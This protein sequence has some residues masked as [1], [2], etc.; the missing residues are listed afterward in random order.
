MMNKY[1]FIRKV[2]IV[3]FLFFLFMNNVL[4]NETED[5]L[6]NLSDKIKKM[7]SEI[8][9]DNFLDDFYPIGSIYITTNSTNPSSVLGGEWEAYAQGRTLIGFGSNG[10]N[11]YNVLGAEGGNSNIKIDSV[12]ILPRH[13][14]SYTADGTITNISFKGNSVSTSTNSWSHSHTIPIY[15]SWNEPT[16]L[17]LCY[18]AN[19]F[20]H[21]VMISASGYATATNGNAGSHTH[22]VVPKG[23]VSSVFNGTSSNLSYF[24]SS[25]VADLDVRNPYVTVYIWKR[26]N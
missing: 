11:N 5:I 12:D 10:V 9:S 15:G 7:T 4:A 23:N 6:N 1:I 24:G 16:G 22:T 8:E 25:N 13:L 3:N 18:Y 21:S 17:G 19:G 14:H 26:I 2:I 20:T